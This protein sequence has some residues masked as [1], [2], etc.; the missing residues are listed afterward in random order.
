[1]AKMP[2][3]MLYTLYHNQIFL[4]KNIYPTQCLDAV[5]VHF[6]LNIYIT[7]A[8]ISC[9]THNTTNLLLGIVDKRDFYF[10]LT[11]LHTFQPFS[12]ASTI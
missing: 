11:L 8:F 5:L 6:L 7:A 10:F 1:M 3:F 4:K 2:Y 9:N 12:S